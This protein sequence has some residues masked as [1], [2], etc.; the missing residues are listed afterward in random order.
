MKNGKIYQIL[1]FF[2]L[3]VLLSFGQVHGQSIGSDMEYSKAELEIINVQSSEAEFVW[4]FNEYSPG[5]PIQWEFFHNNSL[6]TGLVFKSPRPISFLSFYNVAIR[7]RANQTGTYYIKREGS[8]PSGFSVFFRGSPIYSS[9]QSIS[10]EAG[11][12]RTFTMNVQNPSNSSFGGNLELS[13]YRSRTLLPDV[14]IAGVLIPL[15]SDATPPSAAVNALPPTQTS[16]SFTVNWSGNDNHSGGSGIWKY[17]VQVRVN[18]GNWTNWRTNT[19]STSAT[20]TGSP[21]NTYYF[22]ARAHDMVGHVSEYSGHNGDTSTTIPLV[23]NIH[24]S[25]I[26]FLFGNVE[27]GQT[28]EQNLVITNQ[29]SS[30]S[31]ISGN[32]GTTFDGA[33]DNF[34][35][36]SGGGNYTLSPGQSRTVR[37]RFTPTAPA[38]TKSAAFQVTHN[39]TN[40]NSPR[41]IG[42]GGIATSPPVRNIS[43][44]TTSLNFG[45][46]EIGDTEDRQFT[47]TNQSSSNST[48]TGSVGSASGNF[49]ITNGG[50]SFSLSPGSS[51]TVTVRF[52]PS[53][54]SGNKSG[55]ISITH[56]AT[57]Q[58]SPTPVSLSGTATSPPVRNISLST[59]SLNFGSVEIGDTEDRQFTITNQSSSNSTLTGSVGSASGNF[60]ITN[61]GGSF[62][63]SP[64][65]SRTVTVRFTPSGSSGNKSGSISITHDATNQSSPT[66]VSLSGTATS[67]PANLIVSPSELDFSSVQV[68]QTST[69][70]YTLN[71]SNLTSSVTISAPDGYQV[72]QNQSSGFSNSITVS[73]SGG[74]ISD[75]TIYVRFS[76]TGAT[77]FSG[78]VS[79]QATGATTR[80]VAVSGVGTEVPQPTLTVNPATLDFGEVEIGQNSTLEYTLSGSNLTSEVTVSAP[81]DFQ[82]SES[83]D[84]DYSSSLTLSPTDGN[85]SDRTIYVRFSPT[86]ATSVS[87]NVSNVATGATTRNVAVS[88]VGTEV[89]QP[90]LTVN[91]ATLDFGEVEIGQDSIL[92]YTLTGSNLISDV[93]IS[94]PEGF[95]V[96]ESQDSEFSNSI[97][98][99]PTDGTITEQIIYVQFTPNSMANYSGSVGNSVTGLPVQNV[100]VSGMGVMPDNSDFMAV[101][102]ISDQ[103]D[104]AMELIIGTAPD[105]T[106][107]FDP[108]YDQYA[109]P[110][111]PDG[112]FDA[113][114]VTEDDAYFRLFQPTTVDQTTW[115]LRFRPATGAAPVELIWDP[116]QLPEEG[117]FRMVDVIDG[118]FVSLDMR[119]QS[120]LTVSESFI[121]DL[122]VVHSLSQTIER[123][124]SQGW[125]LIGLPVDMPHGSYSD[126][127]TNAMTGTLT[128]FNGS[129][130][131]EETLQPGSG[132]WLR[133]SDQEMATFSGDAIQSLDL[134]LIQSWNLISGVSEATDV[135]AITDPGG[136]IIAGT[137]FVYDGSYAQATAIEP[138]L[139]YWLRTSSPG[140]I[141][142]ATGSPAM[143]GLDKGS[144]TAADLSA[145]SQILIHAGERELLPLYFGATLAKDIHPLSYSMPPLPPSGADARLENDMRVSEA[146]TVRVQLQQSDQ[147]M[148]LELNS[149]DQRQQFIVRQRS[150]EIILGETITESG[151]A[152]EVLAQAEQL[153]IGLFEGVPSEELPAEFVLKQNYPNPFNPVTIISYAL[154]EAADVRLEVYNI[155]GQRVATVVSGN[156]NAGWHS[157]SFDAS[158]LS[159][160]MYIYRLQA[161]S[162]VQIRK[163]VLVK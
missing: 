24:F 38:G 88:G 60:S 105:A 119:T 42:V 34:S 95:Y 159:S 65:S 67:P 11:E 112:A 101:V 144:D 10:M 102:L 70:D 104:N 55:S 141:T 125:S 43:L 109:P 116:E 31:N 163:M 103:N 1:V 140:S 151:R 156:Q 66:P 5:Q 93:T 4:N 110:A 47:I 44:S 21:G 100:E 29:A 8:S 133:F 143:A 154:P 142:I 16:N 19:T 22:R 106:T 41:I 68:G 51:R 3:K 146:E 80:N 49:S 137:I 157:V 117:S 54:S 111:P 87:G 50:G 123:T 18:N 158:R 30:N 108:Q 136:I 63:L 52:T 69:Q 83:Q 129:Y 135:T 75:R 114:I 72:S 118:N 40:T 37:M 33:G 162:F 107:G 134:E 147:Q 132:Y 57:N 139:G 97:A 7:V 90:T 35:I 17:D 48:L 53:G 61:G 26:M 85:I 9:S 94:A 91:P 113:R 36:V 89:P 73:S 92:E 149:E 145:F 96:S 98:L 45:S 161:G 77:S 126:I 27:I 81:E 56:D 124:Y 120:I 155:T 12:T 20:Y 71:G 148:T 122:R 121:T 99:S 58:S 2:T 82:V 46:V 74:S 78:N 84:S 115:N 23:R 127:F 28:A 128:G 14:Y 152:I 62:S 64:G 138:G 131:V 39:A 150:G 25:D 160:G 153:E 76:P 15:A 6:Y 79:N 86:S 59:T 13:I 130:T 32:V